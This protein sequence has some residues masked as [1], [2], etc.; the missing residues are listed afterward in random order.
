MIAAVDGLDWQPSH[1][2]MFRVAPESMPF[3]YAGNLTRAAELFRDYPLNTDNRPVIEY[4]TPITFREVARRDEVVWCVGPRLTDWID[5]IA[6]RAPAEQDPAWSGH[7][8][9]SHHLIRA[10]AAF[11]RTMVAKTRGDAAAA[12]IEW[13]RFLRE[14]RDAALSN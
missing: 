13:G 14:W 9:S 8:E 6:A 7:P 5:R 2:E 3:L 10:G 12:E 11:H 4:Q 1:P